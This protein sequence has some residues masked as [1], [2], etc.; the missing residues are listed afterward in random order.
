MLRGLSLKK[1]EDVRDLTCNPSMIG[2]IADDFIR[3]AVA[4]VVAIRFRAQI[5]ERKH[6]DRVV[7]GLCRINHHRTNGQDC[8]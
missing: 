8:K 6:C 7:S 1:K 4:E 3:Q 5:F 2:E